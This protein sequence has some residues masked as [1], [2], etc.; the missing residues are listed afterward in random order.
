MTHKQFSAKGGK[1]GTG[2]SKARTSE[3]A[4]AAVAARWAKTKRKP[5]R[6]TAKSNTEASRGER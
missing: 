2:A 5:K 6:V 4:R 3:Q 1:S